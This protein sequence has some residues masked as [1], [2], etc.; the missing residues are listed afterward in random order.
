MNN[1]M[2]YQDYFGSIHYSDEDQ[3]LY[4]KNGKANAQKLLLGVLNQSQNGGF[5]LPYPLP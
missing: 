4:G 1:M 3:L 2:Q 5:C